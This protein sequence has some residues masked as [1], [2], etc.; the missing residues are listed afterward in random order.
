[1]VKILSLLLLISLFFSCFE[2]SIVIKRHKTYW[3]TLL[4]IILLKSRLHLTFSLLSILFFFH[5]LQFSRKFLLFLLLLLSVLLPCHLRIILPTFGSF[6]QKFSLLLLRHLDLLQSRI[7]RL[8]TLLNIL[9]C[10]YVLHWLMKIYWIILLRIVLFLRWLYF[11][12]FFPLWRSCFF[13]RAVLHQ[14]FVLWD[15][16][17]L[18]IKCG[19]KRLLFANTQSG[20]GFTF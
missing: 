19:D 17:W 15:S 7:I 10:R 2:N 5:F 1:M 18:L 3:G 11:D 8:I 14:R 20:L 6:L 9:A 12:R 4:Y 16:F 13:H